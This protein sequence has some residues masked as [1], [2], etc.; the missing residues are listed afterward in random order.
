MQG[1][2]VNSEWIKQPGKIAM[3][4]IHRL[5][6]R[7]RRQPDPLTYPSPD[8]GEG[9]RD[10][11]G[12][13]IVILGG[14]FV[15]LA[16]LIGLV[17]DVAI[18]YVSWGHLRRTV[19]AAALAG[20]TQFR[21]N[22]TVSDIQASAIEFIR[23]HNIQPTS[24]TVDTCDTDPTLCTDPA[25]KLVR[26]NATMQVNLVFL[27]LLG[28]NSISL[29]AQAIGEAAS[30]DAVLVLD[31]SDSMTYDAP[32]GDPM[33]DP[34][35]CNPIHACHPMEEVKA[36][37]ISFINYLY[38]PYDRVALVSFDRWAHLRQPLSPD[39]PGAIAATDALTVYVPYS[40]STCPSWI[41]PDPP[42]DGPHAHDPS[43]CTS[44]N[45]G[46]GLV[47]GVNEFSRPP[48]R[49]DSVWVM[50]L[51]TD[52]SAN[53]TDPDPDPNPPL[54]YCPGSRDNPDWVQPFCRDDSTSRH[55]SSSP[56]Y[57]ADDYARDMADFVGMPPPAGSLVAIYTIGLGNQ[58]IQADCGLNPCNVPDAGEKLLRYIAA[59][60]DDG[61][62]NT[63]PCAG[64]PPSTLSQPQPCGN[65]YF[66]PTGAELQQIFADIASRIFTRINK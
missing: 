33:R 56:L 31:T 39:K 21:Q 44:T 55:P 53:A 3:K 41:R 15:A 62:P 40:P 49:T 50:I 9:G 26:V 2:V 22:R 1:R 16:I 60:G 24:V 5:F 10:E 64:V 7:S 42:P 4:T 14:A 34:N 28:W 48:V 66:A 12:Q 35:N 27:R 36:A 57:D 63:D 58:V 32:P 29:S 43:E 17:T 37:A 23:L 19:D 6:Q 13:A 45:I 59:V 18:A 11:G 20:A 47:L 46:G 65:Y 52:G 30:I 38:D 54:G 8:R 51:L 61:N 25:R